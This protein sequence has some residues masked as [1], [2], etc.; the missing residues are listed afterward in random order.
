[1]SDLFAPFEES[2]I[3]QPSKNWNEVQSTNWVAKIFLLTSPI[4]AVIGA[5]WYIKTYGFGFGELALWSSM[6]VITGLGITA[7]Y[8]RCFSHRTHDAHPILQFIY[9][10]LGASVLQQNVIYWSRNHRIHHRFA[11]TELD[12]HNIKQGFFHA[13]MGWIFQNRPIDSDFS[14]VKDLLAQPLMTWQMKYYWPIFFVTG[15][16]L[17]TLLGWLFLDS[18]AAGF[19]WGVLVRL[20]AQN[21]CVFS[22]NSV[23]HTLGKQT[24]SLKAEARDSL[25]LVFFSNG[26]GYHS[27]H[28]RFA[29]DYRNGHAWYHW[30]P[31]KWFIRGMEK[32]GLAS[33]L[34]LAPESAIIKARVS[35]ERQ[36]ALLALQAMPQEKRTYWEQ[37]MHDAHANY[38][39]MHI[40]WQE[41]KERFRVY[42]AE[43]KQTAIANSRAEYETLKTKLAECKRNMRLSQQHWSTIA[44]SIIFFIR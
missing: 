41:A 39:A 6:H 20:V 42:K 21:H 40:Q 28:H 33:N 2:E 9:L 16:I 30:D 19:V 17:P 44:A 10:M 27:F 7:G 23:A 36:Q 29:S 34:K 3:L 43:R 8:H 38:E 11:D 24:Y 22:I 14:T 37:K 18:L 5:I 26:E 25:F 1:M 31:S 15:V 4:A 32:L 35:T 12:P 13:H